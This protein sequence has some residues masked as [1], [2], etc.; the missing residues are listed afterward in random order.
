M[1]E[2]AFIFLISPPH[3]DDAPIQGMIHLAWLSL[4]Q[5]TAGDDPNLPPPHTHLYLVTP[6]LI[7]QVNNPTEKSKRTFADLI[8][9]IE[10][11]ATQFNIPST[12]IRKISLSDYLT[13]KRR[14]DLE[15]SLFDIKAANSRHPDPPTILP[16]KETLKRFLPLNELPYIFQLIDQFFDRHHSSEGD[17]AKLPYIMGR[18]QDIRANITNIIN[19]ANTTM[20]QDE[21]RQNILHFLEMHND[22]STRQFIDL[23]DHKKPLKGESLESLKRLFTTSYP[24][25]KVLYETI[26]NHPQR[27]A[28][29]PTNELQPSDQYLALETIAFSRWI[30]QLDIETDG[31]PVHFTYISANGVTL[32]ATTDKGISFFNQQIKAALWYQETDTLGQ[33]FKGETSRPITKEALQ[34]AIEKQIFSAMRNLH[35][36][37]KIGTLQTELLNMA[38][39]NHMEHTLELK[40]ERS[41]LST[42]LESNKLFNTEIQASLKEAWSS[43]SVQIQE[44]LSERCIGILSEELN[45][46][47]QILLLLNKVGEKIKD[48]IK[49]YISSELKAAKQKGSKTTIDELLLGWFTLND[50]SR[51][52]CRVSISDT[53]LYQ[54]QSECSLSEHMIIKSLIHHK[55]KIEE[56]SAQHNVILQAISEHPPKNTT[57]NPQSILN[58]IK[59]LLETAP[60]IPMRRGASM[61]AIPYRLHISPGHHSPAFIRPNNSHPISF[62]DSIIEHVDDEDLSSN[63]TGSTNTLMQPIESVGGDIKR[64]FSENDLTSR[65]LTNSPTRLWAPPT[66]PRSNPLPIRQH[67]QPKQPPPS[68][69]GIRKRNSLFGINIPLWA[70][71]GAGV[72]CTLIPSLW[73]MNS[74]SKSDPVRPLFSR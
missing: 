41:S 19:Q 69:E 54:L 10:Q 53:L 28:E 56:N 51:T 55:T 61:D 26:A 15:S 68:P 4:A 63:H 1:A 17:S 39:Y 30:P 18:K 3:N 2:R 32:S 60:K 48:D 24:L 66:S 33:K 13:E 42:L 20:R 37:S 45:L 46:K 21:Y 22:E 44:D 47:N 14:Q 49:R 64:T 12:D 43:L 29:L 62:S 8:N 36:K 58:Y 11:I 23:L 50:D 57:R 38:K 72:I 34:K 40:A 9:K 6:G 5:W 73:W 71:F 74:H 27:A 59:E 16:L 67:H 7:D 52:N 31:I 65:F 35:H 25:H 70:A